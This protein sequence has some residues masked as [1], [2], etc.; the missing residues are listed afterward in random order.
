MPTA[1]MDNNGLPHAQDQ[2]SRFECHHNCLAVIN[3]LSFMECADSRDAH[4]VRFGQYSE[5]S[6]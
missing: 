5:V 6:R 1:D 4:L 3:H 2:A